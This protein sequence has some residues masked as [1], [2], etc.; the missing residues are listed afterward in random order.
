MRQVNTAGIRFLREKENL[1]KKKAQTAV[2][3]SLL[4]FDL[5]VKQAYT[6]IMVQVFKRK[7]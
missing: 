5:L 6:L 1:K 2:R 4:L 3:L 7:K